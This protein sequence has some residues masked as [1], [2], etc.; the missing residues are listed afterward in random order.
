VL[1]AGGA[2]PEGSERTPW[3]RT[4]TD[5]RLREKGMSKRR[6][7]GHH[8]A[9]R[10]REACRSRLETAMHAHPECG[11]GRGPGNISARVIAMPSWPRAPPACVCRPR[12]IFLSPSVEFSSVPSR[13]RRIVLPAC[14]P[15]LRSHRPTCM[16]HFPRVRVYSRRLDL[17]CNHCFYQYIIC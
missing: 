1:P 14:A 7:R 2:A 9:P 17:I 15:R 6:R 11:C 10:E 16:Q 5:R 3:T 12:A 4:A 8:Q 13:N